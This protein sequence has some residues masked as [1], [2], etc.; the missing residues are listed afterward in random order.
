MATEST[1]IER[2]HGKTVERFKALL[3]PGAKAAYIG[4]VGGD[5]FHFLASRW[6]GAGTRMHV[7]RL[8]THN[9]YYDCD[10][11]DKTRR[12]NLERLEA[13]LV[14]SWTAADATTVVGKIRTTSG[15][16]AGALGDATA[17]GRALKRLA[18]PELHDYGV[19]DEAYAFRA[20]LASFAGR[21]VAVVSP[22]TDE[23][24]AQ[25]AGKR[26]V[27]FSDGPMPGFELV[28][29]K[30]P[31]T[32]SQPGQRETGTFP[33]ADFFETLDVLKSQLSSL[34]FDVALLGCGLYAAPL[35]A[36]A[37]SLGRHAVYMGG[38]LQVYFGVLGNRYKHVT[39]KLPALQTVHAVRPSAPP[40]N[41]YRVM[42]REAI[43]AY[44]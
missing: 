8:H 7:S 40:P 23:I 38:A 35:G 14:E 34:E 11:D 26:A 25:Y 22:F 31:V 1:H 16:Y 6:A 21:R 24:A 41:T 9:G 27:L 13:L 43:Q 39:R 18:L 32:Y 4:R 30:T 33:H 44:W 20:V 42:G 37:K 28:T 10:P 5:D 15:F 36:F 29:L 2:N 19:M 3:A 17:A 12:D